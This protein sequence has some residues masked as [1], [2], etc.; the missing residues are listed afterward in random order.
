MAEGIKTIISIAILVGV[1]TFSA[2]SGLWMFM[3]KI[4]GVL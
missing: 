2:T 4:Q 1:I 3:G